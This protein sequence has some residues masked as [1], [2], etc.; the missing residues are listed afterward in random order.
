[1]KFNEMQL[2]KNIEKALV[3]LKYVEATE[4][5]EKTIPEIIKGKDVIGQS[6]TGTG[7]TAAFGLPIIQGIDISI[8]TTQAIVILP[9]REL[10]VQV[11]EELKKFAKYISGL[12]IAIVY[13]GQGMD[14]QIQALRKGAHIVVG[15]PGRMMDHLRRRTLKLESVKTVVLDEADE[16]LNMGFEEDIETI[17]QTVPTKRQTVLFSATLSPRIMKITEKYLTDPKNIKIQ[18]RSLTV[19]KI[20]QIVIE[21]RSKEKDDGVI[22][23]LDYYEPKKCVIFCNTKSKV[24]ELSDLLRVNGYKADGLHG[25]MNQNQREKIMRKLKSGDTNILIA[26]DVAARGIDVDGLELVINYDVPQEVEYYVHRIGRTGRKGNT[27]VAVTFTTSRGRKKLEELERYLKTK[28]KLTNLPDDSKL[29]NKRNLAIQ[30]S[31]QDVID[32]NRFQFSEVYNELIEFNGIEKVTKALFTMFVNK[33]VKKAEK[34]SSDFENRQEN[35]SN[36]RDRNDRFKKDSGKPITVSEGN[37]KLFVNIGKLDKIEKKDII[38]LLSNKA[39][40]KKEEIGK[41]K[42]LDKFS[43]V[44][45]PSNK[46]EKIISELDG[47]HLNGRHLG[48]EIAKN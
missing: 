47:K 48:V 21:L 3:D 7:K 46:A 23:I 45:V 8:K 19:D 33:T 30:K 29:Q 34:E 20:Q 32:S 4:I 41:V 28:F 6:Q 43:F 17:L 24:D 2:A 10:A 27:G 16:M 11:A 31:I 9:T 18:N 44:E 42:I 36:R 14:T 12:N 1:M 39:N 26:T 40:I 37:V 13:G 5:Q 22:K 38:D 35:R 25:D 15:T